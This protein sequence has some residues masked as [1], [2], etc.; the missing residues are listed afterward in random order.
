MACANGSVNIQRRQSGPT[1]AQWDAIRP[2]F[3]E[4]YLQESPRL[5]LAAIRAYLAQEYDFH[6][7]KHN[8]MHR[9]KQWGIC[10]NLKAAQAQQIAIEDENFLSRGLAPPLR[11]IHQRVVKP[12]KIRRHIRRN[13]TLA[14][15]RNE[16][17]RKSTNSLR[18]DVDSVMM[19]A[20]WKPHHRANSLP[21]SPAPEFGLQLDE[22]ESGL[23]SIKA[24]HEW[25]L[26]VHSPPIR[27]AVER[28][29]W[30]GDQ[31]MMSP[32][33]ERH[34]WFGSMLDGLAVFDL[35][36]RTNAWNL[37][38]RACDL[39]WRCLSA[40]PIDMVIELVSA[41]WFS[42]WS[43]CPEFK[44]KLQQHFY[45]MSRSRLDFHHPLVKVLDIIRSKQS[46]SAPIWRAGVRKLIGDVVYQSPW[47]QSEEFLVGYAYL[48]ESE[49]HANSHDLDIRCSLDQQVTKAEAVFGAKHRVTHEVKLRQAFALVWVGDPTQAQSIFQEILGLK[50]GLANGDESDFPEDWHSRPFIVWTALNYLAQTHH[51]LGEDLQ[52]LV[53]SKKMFEFSLMH[54]LD[55]ADI[56][57]SLMKL[58]DSLIDMENWTQLARLRDEHPDLHDKMP[59]RHSTIRNSTTSSGTGG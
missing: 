58:E 52:S 24:W 27:R 36:F 43:K 11:V 26:H 9:I 29:D 48:L 2:I 56:L 51:K 15:I 19:V 55:E 53:Y 34:Y 8:Y 40:P 33:P 25:Y 32:N 6:A 31:A 20:R 45:D 50:S 5:T 54:K 37:F 42:D 30:R 47:S 1:Q 44:N 13:D 49:I 7:Q 4:L 18:T 12:D 57:F 17:E 39:F 28:D 16:A 3:R 14:R 21:R 46:E 38:N 35:G 10:R 41:F 23:H 22:A 59:R